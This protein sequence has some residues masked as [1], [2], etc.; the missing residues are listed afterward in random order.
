M[1]I[2]KVKDADL[3]TEKKLFWLKVKTSSFLFI[4]L[5]YLRLTSGCQ[6]T[7]MLCMKYLTETFPLSFYLL[8][9]VLFE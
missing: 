7:D 9:M 5:I 3:S 6:L 4:S 1:E 2:I 8:G